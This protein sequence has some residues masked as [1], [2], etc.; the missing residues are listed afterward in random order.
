MRKRLPVDRTTRSGK[1]W[2][3]GTLVVAMIFAIPG[4]P[5]LWAQQVPPIV[6]ERPGYGESTLTVP[7]GFVQVEMGYTFFRQDPLDQQTIGELLIRFPLTDRIELRLLGN[8]YLVQKTNRGNPVEGMEDAGVGVKFQLS[9]ST[10]SRFDLMHPQTVLIVGTTIPTGNRAF[11][12]GKP[13]PSVKFGIE[14]PLNDRF[15]VNAFFNGDWS[16]DGDRYTTQWSSS[17]SVGANLTETLSSFVE[18]YGI[19]PM[20]EG[21]E[22]TGFVDGGVTYLFNDNLAWDVH[23]GWQ[24]LGEGN[25]FFIGSGLIARF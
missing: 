24:V 17:F 8:S 10:G 19:F 13:Q 9:R 12:A 25:G 5:T 11:R 20:A 21:L 3:I 4:H 23:A 7:P 16:V 6:G 15:S 22:Q 2:M 18:V 14:Y 1:G